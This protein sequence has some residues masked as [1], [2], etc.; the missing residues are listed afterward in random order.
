M[1]ITHIN[2][3]VNMKQLW[4]NSDSKTGSL[5]VKPVPMPLCPPQIQHGLTWAQTQACMEK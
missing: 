2:T 3:E 1:S 4:N 5:K